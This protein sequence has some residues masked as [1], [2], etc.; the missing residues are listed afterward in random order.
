MLPAAHGDA[1]L[2][3]WGTNRERHHMLVDAGPLGTYASIHDR[4]TDLGTSPALEL[5]VVTHIDGDHIE[6]VIRLL[7]DRHALGLQIGDVW[8]NGWPQLPA[9]DR[10]GPDYGEMVGALVQR[11][12]LPWNTPYG[13]NAVAVPE[14]GPLPSYPLNGGAHVTLLGPGLSQLRKLKANWTKVLADVDVTPGQVDAALRRLAKRK[15]L[16]GLDVQG[17]TAKPDNSVSNGSSISMLF[18]Y[19][20]RALLLTGDSHSA[21]LVAG[22]QRLLKE[23]GK[24]RLH[25]DAFKLPH[26]CSQANVTDELLA[27]VE[28]PRY[29][30]STNG[31]RYRHPDKEAI[32]RVV[33]QL[34]RDSDTKLFFNYLS[35]TTAQWT[36][37]A[38]A[39][40]YR[41]A[42]IFPEGGTAGIVVEV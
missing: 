31:D 10:L 34:E 9:T 37:P 14:Q 23:R 11:G 1:L 5:L 33:G 3:Q 24:D 28:T 40:K 41:Y 29:L 19:D 39:K 12:E 7:Q 27:L 22:I 18:E 17:R 30:V 4:L 21:P 25:V 26:H 2:V 32:L 15:D 8:F 36:K 6:G 20:N 16:K 38:T 42:P 13:G 35:K